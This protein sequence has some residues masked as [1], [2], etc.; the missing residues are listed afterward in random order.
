MKKLL[1]SIKSL[2]SPKNTNSTHPRSTTKPTLFVCK[3]CHR[4][5]EERPKNQLS[6]GT[7]L[8]DK[9][10]SLRSKDLTSE[11]LE[12][13]PVECLWACSQGCVASISSPDKPTY[14]FV[15][16]PTDES[17]EAL[18]EFMQMYIK[19][20]KGNIAWKKFPKLLQSAIFASIPPV[21][22]GKK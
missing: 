12:I 10:N 9:L 7:I 3:S 15:N 6:D 4:S 11:D 5:S 13:K 18:L 2:I 16:L 20:R 22:T 21:V 17:P 8:L 19:S 14:L 1:A